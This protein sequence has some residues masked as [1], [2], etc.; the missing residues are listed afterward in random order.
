MTIPLSE[1]IF[2]KNFSQLQDK[3]QQNKQIEIFQ[4]PETT[5]AQPHAMHRV[6][7]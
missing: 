1:K 4:A 5:K 3:T 7:P 6:T 2:Q